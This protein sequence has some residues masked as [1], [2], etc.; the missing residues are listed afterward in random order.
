MCVKSRKN[1]IIIAK[2]I[3]KIVNKLTKYTIH[4]NIKLYEG[5]DILV[6]DTIQAI[7]D[8]EQK[9]EELVENAKKEAAE[10]RE[11]AK[12]EAAKI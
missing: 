9:A 5:G 6:K 3:K 2:N 8:T 12:K 4:S 11:N 10:I 7:K 1:G